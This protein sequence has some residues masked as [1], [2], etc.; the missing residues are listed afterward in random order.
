MS[1]LMDLRRVADQLTPP[2]FADLVAV[3]G[4]RRRRTAAAG[5]LAVAATVAVVAVLTAQSGR[6]DATPPAHSATPPGGSATAG[7]LTLEDLV[8]NPAAT[9]GDTLRSPDGAGATATLWS[10]CRPWGG[11]AAPGSTT[12]AL[13]IEVVRGTHSSNHLLPLTG[14]TN[15]EAL[16]DGWFYVDPN[17]GDPSPDGR[18]AVAFGSAPA[19]LTADAPDPADL[20]D[21]RSS[22]LL[23]ARVGHDVVV[24]GLNRLCV[25]DL[26]RFALMGMDAPPLQWSDQQDSLLW[27]MGDTAAVWLDSTGK[28]HR[29]PFPETTRN[30]FGDGLV[31]QTTNGTMA[32]Y[33]VPADLEL[34]KPWSGRQVLLTVSTD[35]GATWRVLRAPE[36]ARSFVAQSLLPDDWTQWPVAT[37]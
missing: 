36:S 34:E 30:G 5:S 6:P 37:G 27:G 12:C 9:R 32:F 1:D 11:P 7:P 16:P 15:V 29:H 18:G 31:R 22:T 17:V 25:V 8:Q 26:D 13:A 10:R 23:P 20:R 14:Y 4:R 21:L 28:V 2:D 3:A 19:L 24:C 35:R 33:R